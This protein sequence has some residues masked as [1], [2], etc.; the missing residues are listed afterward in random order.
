MSFIGATEQGRTFAPG[1]FLESEV[2]VVRKTRQIAQA[3]AKENGDGSKYVPMGTV[4]PANDATAEGIVY[5][6]IDV[7][8]GDMPGSVVLAG[9]VYEDRIPAAI[10]AGAKTALA[11]KGFTFIAASPAVTR[12]Y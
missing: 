7:T 1:W 12:P 5:E 10:A 8:T 6:D 3:G 2:G 9:R 11:E 4:W